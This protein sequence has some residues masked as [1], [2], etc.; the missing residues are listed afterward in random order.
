MIRRLSRLFLAC[1]LAFNLGCANSL[2]DR[3]LVF[4]T[5]TSLGIEVSVDPAN[6]SAPVNLLMGYKRYEGVLNPV[7]YDH[8]AYPLERGNVHPIHCELCGLDGESCPHNAPPTDLNSYYRLQAY[9]VLAK[10]RG[11]SSADA[12]DN[13]EGRIEVAQWF[14]TGKA[15]DILACQPGIAAAVSGSPEIAEA[16]RGLDTERFPASS[17]VHAIASVSV[18]RML[19]EA[20]LR[21]RPGGPGKTPAD[22]YIRSQP[23]HGATR[24]DHGGL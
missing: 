1:L 23:A 22:G 21:Q 4:S 19:S 24:L 15:A 16:L 14:A 7:F 5:S 18:Y 3:S 8:N 6:S 2:I 20:P 9:S 11:N 17:T 12:G 10:I 13:V